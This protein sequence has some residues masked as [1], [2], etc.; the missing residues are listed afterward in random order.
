MQSA[1]AS[2]SAAGIG[3]FGNNGDSYG[4]AGRSLSLG[5]ESSVSA[6]GATEGFGGE[7]SMLNSTLPGSAGSSRGASPPAIPAGG[8]G[9]SGDNNA[10]A[11]DF[12][13]P[14]AAPPP[15]LGPLGAPTGISTAGGTEGSV[16][17]TAS[18]LRRGGRGASAKV[19]GGG[20]GLVESDDD[21]NDNDGSNHPSAPH[22]RRRS[23]TV[24]NP[25]INYNP[26]QQNALG[27]NF[28][29]TTSF[30]SLGRRTP[31]AAGASGRAQQLP[32]KFIPSAS[33]GAD[34][35][36]VGGGASGFF[37]APPAQGGGGGAS[38]LNLSIR[39]DSGALSP[40]SA[41]SNN[42]NEEASSTHL[43]GSGKQQS[44]SGGGKN[45]TMATIMAATP[46]TALMAAQINGVGES[47][48]AN[49]DR[50]FIEDGPIATKQGLAALFEAIDSSDVRRISWQQLTHFLFEAALMERV[51]A[52]DLDTKSYELSDM[53][54]FEARSNVRAMQT[55]AASER[56]IRARG[57]RSKALAAKIKMK[58]QERM[59]AGL[60]EEGAGGGLSDLSH[61][62]F[63]EPTKQ[64]L[65]GGA[66][67]WWVD[68]GTGFRPKL[69]VETPRD[70][71]SDS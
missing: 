10:D 29:R 66:D 26:L 1:A 30:S 35:N 49:A 71:P 59:A 3:G 58:N 68:K 7:L 44:S 23:T 55:L 41:T 28:Q 38:S 17:A 22:S 34:G 63:F 8:G 25:N 67:L 6:G 2:S 46:E 54:P 57:V 69:K 4:M 60:S 36:F 43:S 20:D 24:L 42:I 65:V 70:G 53:S 13:T 37:T 18:S 31:A 14:T 32:A 11:N 39:S 50:D 61:L 52:V 51:G 21:P 16:S 19:S 27:G 12:S 5:A 62:T 56:E 47:D 64:L 15:Q 48:I 33:M 9:V 45:A 40:F